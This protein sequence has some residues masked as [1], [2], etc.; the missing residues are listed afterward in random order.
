LGEFNNNV[1]HSNGRY[2]L[3]IFHNHIPRVKQCAALNYDT[4]SASYNPP[5]PAIYKNLVSYKNKRN[6]AIIERAGAVEWHNFKTADN[7]E[8]GMEMSR[9]GDNLRHGYAK[10]IGGVVVGKSENTEEALDKA[11][12]MGVRTPRTEYFEMNDTKFYN[13]NW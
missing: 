2:G 6:G 5:I 13:F 1:A 8:V 4:E 9:T 3:R 7:L 12:P 10:I 11:S